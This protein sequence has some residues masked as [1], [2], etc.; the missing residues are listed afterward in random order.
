LPESSLMCVA[1]HITTTSK[2]AR[3]GDSSVLFCSSRQKLV[4]QW[5]VLALKASANAELVALLTLSAHQRSSLDSLLWQ[6]AADA[7]L[8]IERTLDATFKG[9]D[10]SVRE[11]WI[12]AEVAGRIVGTTHA[13]M[14]PV[15]PIYESTA[16]SPGLFLD[17]CTISDNAP[18]GTAE[19]LLASTEEALS[20]GGASSLIASCPTAGPLRRLYEA[21]GYEPVTL[22][23]TKHGFSP[24][25]LPLGI[26]PAEE[27][28]VGA[29]VT[30]SVA[31]RKTL[32]ALHPKFWRIHPQADGRFDAWMRRS[33]TLK[34]RDLFVA[35]GAGGAVRG[36]VIAQPCSSL[37]IPTGHEALG[38]IDDFYDQ[39]FANVSAVADHERRGE[40]LLAAAESAFARRSV[41]TALAVCPAAWSSKISLL[42]QRGFRS[43]KIWMLKR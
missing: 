40:K 28:D 23:M 18:S 22:Y 36:Y 13:M 9:T 5:Q 26:R 3:N 43:A 10:T 34:D 32:A 42:E 17:D 31:H 30:L 20:K 25:A 15:P 33:L 21:R 35:I 39:D 37:L 7:S 12:V 11:L 24:D 8:Q 16:G 19:T 38:V 41:Y 4:S 29:I 2:T 1:P 27:D 14:V 6:V